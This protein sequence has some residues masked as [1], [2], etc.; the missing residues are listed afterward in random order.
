MKKREIKFRVWDKELNQWVSYSEYQSMPSDWIQHYDSNPLFELKPTNM[1]KDRFI[2]QQYTGLKDKNGI[3]IYEGDFVK[4][5]LCM[6]LM[7]GLNEVE[8]SD[9][10][11][12]WTIRNYE[13]NTRCSLYRVFPTKEV[14]GNIM[15]LT[16]SPY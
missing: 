15:E 9:I 1:Y 3:E 5:E 6:V 10:E 13:K 11:G 2:I 14:I 7:Q 12:G 8:W 4:T 16:Y